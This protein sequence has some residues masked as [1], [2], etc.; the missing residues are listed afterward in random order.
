MNLRSGR[1]KINLF[2]LDALV[3]IA[4]AAGLKTEMRPA[5]PRRRLAPP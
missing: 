5:A 4:A 2:A 1:G 3:N